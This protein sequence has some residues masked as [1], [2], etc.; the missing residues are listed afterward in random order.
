MPFFQ[1]IFVHFQCQGVFDQRRL[2]RF[3]GYSAVPVQ[4]G[5][6]LQVYGNK[7]PSLFVQLTLGGAAQEE[8]DDPSRG[9]TP[10]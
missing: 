1:I 7:Q 4:L 8:T 5:V 10:S 6:F 9:F 2:G 3:A